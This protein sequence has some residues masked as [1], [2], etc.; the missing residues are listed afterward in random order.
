MA[1]GLL[2]GTLH[3]TA[4]CDDSTRH[5]VPSPE[6]PIQRRVTR[7]IRDR[8]STVSRQHYVSQFHLAQFS[9]SD[10]RLWYAD[11]ATGQV[12]RHTSKGIGWGRKVYSD[13]TAV[14][15]PG[16]DTLLAS[17]VENDAPRCFS[18]SEPST[19]PHCRFVPNLAGT[20]RGPPPAPSR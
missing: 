16:I 7:L 19:R 8:L 1:L 4:G 9:D 13:Q 18:R 11:F 15:G 20:L 3:T 10:G 14:G 5:V 17:Q 2:R 12:D 6:S